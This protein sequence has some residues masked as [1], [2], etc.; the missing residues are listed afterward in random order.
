MT[1][2]LKPVLASGLSAWL[3]GETLNR[4]MLAGTGLILVGLLLAVFKRR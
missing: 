1:F 3:L 4:Y 2:F